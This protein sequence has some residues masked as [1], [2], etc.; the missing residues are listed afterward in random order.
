M[1]PYNISFTKENTR[2]YVWFHVGIP[3]LTKYPKL[4]KKFKTYNEALE[5]C[6]SRKLPHKN[7]FIVN[8]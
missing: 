1:E 2:K 7:R 4:A 3:V 8:Y 5:F 6:E